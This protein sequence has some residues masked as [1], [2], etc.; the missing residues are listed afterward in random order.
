MNS[1]SYKETEIG[2]IPEDWKID[3]LGNVTEKITKGT[4]PTT[5][6]K[7]FVDIGIN[8]IK[9]ESIRDDSSFIKNKFMH[10]DSDTNELLERSILEIN[11]ILFSIAGVIGRTAIVTNNILPA[12]TNQAI[13]IIRPNLDLILPKFLKYY[14]STQRFNEVVKSRIVQ[15]AQANVSLSVLSNSPVILPDLIEQ[16]IITNILFS[17]DKKIQLNHQM[18]QTLESIGQAI[19]EMGEIPE[20]WKVIENIAEICDLINYGYTQSAS[21]NRVGPKFLRVMD[22]NKGD[23]INWESVPYC[24]I[25]V[26]KFLKYRLERGDIVIARMADPGKVAIFESDIDA[27]FASYLIRI[28][29]LNPKLSLYLYYLMKSPYYQF[30]IVGASSGT[31]QNNLNAKGLTK[32]LPIVIPNENIIE[33]FNVNIGLLREKINVNIKENQNLSQIRDSLLPKLMSGKIRVKTTEEAI[34]K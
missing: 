28:R 12:N 15:T 27:V 6:G 18:N 17:L 30:Y 2:L 11:D 25:E 9:A 21:E 34:A 8:F 31:V 10:I 16:S 29:L 22:I 3:I 4:T 23:W 1:D 32:G 26:K 20:G 13:A 24:E 5:L 14:L 7:N 33:S 19:S